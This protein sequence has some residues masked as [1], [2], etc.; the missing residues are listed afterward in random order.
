MTDPAAP[1][2]APSPPPLRQDTLPPSKPAPALKPWVPPKAPAPARPAAAAGSA[3]AP[4]LPVTRAADLTSEHLFQRLHWFE[5]MFRHHRAYIADLQARLSRTGT[6]V[7]NMPH[8]AP[9]VS[10]AGDINPNEG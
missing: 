1:P 8:A 10:P 9:L 4:K 7:P 2:V 6:A 3:P 5:N